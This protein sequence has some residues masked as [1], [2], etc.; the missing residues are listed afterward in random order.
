MDL[1]HWARFRE[2][3]CSVFRRLISLD[4]VRLVSAATL[5]ETSV[6]VDG[7]FEGAGEAQLDSLLVASGL[8]VV[9]VD[10]KQAEIARAAFRRYWRGRRPA[11]LNFGDWFSYALAPATDEPLLFKGTDFGLTDVAP[12]WSG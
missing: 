11:E 8:T 10:L 7:R 1:V 4:P 6:V 2:P 12:A 5:I 9:P 3:E